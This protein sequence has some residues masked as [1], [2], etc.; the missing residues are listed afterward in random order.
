MSPARMCTVLT[1]HHLDDLID[2]VKVLIVDRQLAKSDNGATKMLQLQT[3]SNL[4]TSNL[5]GEDLKKF[6][7]KAKYIDL[8]EGH[9]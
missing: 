8:I 1:C 6:P 7:N 9:N 5:V 4:Q 2:V 3:K